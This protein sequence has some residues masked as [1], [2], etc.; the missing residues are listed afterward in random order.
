MS[1]RPI[2]GETVASPELLFATGMYDMS[3]RTDIL[4]DNRTILLPDKS[5]TIALLSDITPSVSPTGLELVGIGWRLI[6]QNIERVTPGLSSVDLGVRDSGTSIGASGYGATILN[7][8]DNKSRGYTSIA[9]GYGNDAGREYSWAIGESNQSL[10]FAD[11]SIGYANVTNTFSYGWTQGMSNSN[12]GANSTVSG[13]ALNN[14]NN[15]GA[16]LFG[17]S[18]E[19]FTGSGSS[20][21]GTDRIFVVG[22]GTF[23][24]PAGTPC[25]A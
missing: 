2:E 23:T 4:T 7:G 20:R 5:G 3:L 14:D 11:K 21:L 13:L 15:W 25:V 1:A 16:A 9:S 22:N 24:T 18:N 6:G 8:E 12:T 17:A 10:G 19:L